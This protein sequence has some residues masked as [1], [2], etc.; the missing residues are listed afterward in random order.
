MASLNETTGITEKSSE[1]LSLLETFITYFRHWKFFLLSITI[2][3]FSGFLYIKLI[4]PVYKIETDLLIKDNKGNTNGQND[5]LKDLGLFSSEKII[6]NEV[7]ILKSNTILEKVI[8]ELKLQTSYI[9]TKGVRNREFYKQFPFEVNLLNPS[10]IA[11]NRVFSFT[12]INEH[13]AI[14]DGKKVLLNS[15]VTSGAGIIQIRVLDSTLINSHFFGQPIK[16]KF[17]DI[18]SILQAYQKKLNIEP[19]SKQATVLIITLED[20]IP[21]RGEDFLNKLIDEYNLAA[22]EDKNRVTSNTLSFI[23]DRLH[24]IA[25]ELGSVEKN[26]E[27]FKS[28]N[29]ITDISSDSQV[30][31]DNVKDNDFQLNKVIIQLSVLNNLETYLHSNQNQSSALPS[32]LGIDDPTLLGLVSKLGEA[33]LRRESLLQT[34]P[35]TNPLVVTINNQITLLKQAIEESVINLKKGVEITQQQLQT[36]NNQYTSIIKKV[37]SKERGLLDV[38]R[39]QDIKN[40]LF[41]Y[42]LQKRE[43]TAMSLASTVADSRT[44]DLAKTSLNPVKPVKRLI[45]MTFFFISIAIPAMVIY[46]RERLNF[47]VTRRTDVEKVTQIPILAEISQSDDSYPLLVSTKPR[48]MVSEQIRV[49]RTNLQ[50]VLTDQAQKV[51]LF[52]SSISG[53][54]KSFVSL[55]LGGALAMAGKKVIILELD[56]RK[57]KLHSGLSIDNTV[58]LSNFLIGQ[59]NYKDIIKEVSQQPGYFIVPSGPIPPNPA[60]LLSNGNV[61]KLIENLKKE[62]DYIILDAPPIGLVT[63]AQILGKYADLTLFIIRHNYTAKNHLHAIDNYYRENKFKRMNIILNSVDLQM[64]YGSSYGYGYGY[65]YGYQGGYY[66]NEKTEKRFSIKNLFSAKK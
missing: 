61:G 47:K 26:V 40:A 10:S 30:F 32:M 28:A 39:Q 9:D 35:D 46:F 31:L 38:M 12:L 58:G 23:N 29:Q 57:P 54:G 5:L 33:Q 59:V 50:F 56:L 7:Q 66:D 1:E 65:G 27:K 55:N 15:S 20:E 21:Q 45:Y 53:E 36:K 22:I 4:T 11:Y 3:M 43:E 62:F 8:K 42:L 24:V 18:N 14:F 64:G 41:T 48:S 17:Y 2:C 52:T 19:A 49:L 37:P 60:E 16:I 63:D 6:D 51:L 34:V 44:I 25:Q 13:E